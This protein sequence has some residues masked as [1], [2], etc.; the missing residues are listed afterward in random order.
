MRENIILKST[1]CVFA[2]NVKFLSPSLFRYTG[3]RGR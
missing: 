3:D 1:L 2:V